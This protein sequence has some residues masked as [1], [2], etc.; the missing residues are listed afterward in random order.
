MTKY[1]YVATPG[2]D[3]AALNA[4]LTEDTLLGYF[5]IPENP[6]AD[7]GNAAYVTRKLTN[8]DVRRW[9]ELARDGRRA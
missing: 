8:Q 7:G 4:M 9:Y 5:V 1:R 6:L 2:M 3:K